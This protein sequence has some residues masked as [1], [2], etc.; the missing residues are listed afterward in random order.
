MERKAR[1]SSRGNLITGMKGEFLETPFG[2]RIAILSFYAVSESVEFSQCTSQASVV[3]KL[4]NVV[5]ESLLLKILEKRKVIKPVGQIVEY[6][7]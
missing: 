1:A 6:I 4:F 2:H 3:S 5:V 7:I